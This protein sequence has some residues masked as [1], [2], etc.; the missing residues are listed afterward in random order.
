[1]T[2]GSV[3]TPVSGRAGTIS[4]SAVSAASIPATPVSVNMPRFIRT[5]GVAEQSVKS[6]QGRSSSG[7]RSPNSSVATPISKGFDSA[8]TIATTRCENSCGMCDS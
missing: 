4:V 5:S 1:M 6:Y 8:V 7:R 3:G 2:A